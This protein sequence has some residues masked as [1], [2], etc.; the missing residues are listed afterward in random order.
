MVRTVSEVPV[1]QTTQR[2]GLIDRPVLVR[3]IG[4]PAYLLHQVEHKIDLDDIPGMSSIEG[5]G[6]LEGSLL[7]FINDHAAHATAAVAQVA[8]N[9]VKAMPALPPTAPAHD[10]LVGGVKRSIPGVQEAGPLQLAVEGEV[11]GEQPL[12]IALQH[13]NLLALGAHQEAEAVGHSTARRLLVGSPNGFPT[14]Q[15][16]SRR[17]ATLHF[18]GPR[19]ISG[20]AEAPTCTCTRAET[21]GWGL[22]LMFL[23]SPLLR[24]I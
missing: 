7:L 23:L 9:E 8:M 20:G 2:D 13:F 21:A 3:P 1:D 14:E 24:D 19:L 6:G 5:R 22:P 10:D 15:V 17:M 11:F 18:A 4:D 16:P 12:V